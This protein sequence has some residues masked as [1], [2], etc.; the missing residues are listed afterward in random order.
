MCHHYMTK[1]HG[2]TYM[3]LHLNLQNNMFESFFIREKTTTVFFSVS[4]ANVHIINI[5]Y[6]LIFLVIWIC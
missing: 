2:K 3:Y 4:L 5:N 1:Q 6:T